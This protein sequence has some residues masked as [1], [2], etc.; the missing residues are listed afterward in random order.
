ME[1]ARNRQ[2]Y[3]VPR[4]R[5]KDNF[6]RKTIR[7]RHELFLY[8]IRELSLETQYKRTTMPDNDERSCAEEW[9]FS[10]LAMGKSFLL[11]AYRDR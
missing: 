10:G 3:S 6:I 7:N 11:F 4:A 8:L 2:A 1:A 5:Y 9:N